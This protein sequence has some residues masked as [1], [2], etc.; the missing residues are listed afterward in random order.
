[1]LRLQAELEARETEVM[2]LQGQ[3]VMAR[4][5]AQDDAN[6]LTPLPDPYS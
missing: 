3:L 4:Q 5:A 1:V 2:A 6:W